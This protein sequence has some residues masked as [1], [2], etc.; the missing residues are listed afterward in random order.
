MVRIIGVYGHCD[1]HQCE[2]WRCSERC[3]LGLGIG[4]NQCV[5]GDMGENI[6]DTFSITPSFTGSYTRQ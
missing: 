1:T 4:A 5:N 3:V 6:K 2:P